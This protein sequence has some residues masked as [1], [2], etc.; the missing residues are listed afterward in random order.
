MVQLQLHGRVG[1]RSAAID[2]TLEDSAG[3]VVMLN[4]VGFHAVCAGH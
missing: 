3:V 2:R 1:G 4:E